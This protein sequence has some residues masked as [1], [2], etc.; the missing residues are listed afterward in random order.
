MRKLHIILGAVI[1]LIGGCVAL[2]FTLT[3]GL[4]GATNDFFTL[5]SEGETQA[6]YDSTAIE[7]QEA[8]SFTEFVDFVEYLELDDYVSSTWSHREFENNIGFVQGSVTLSDGE[9]LPLRVDLV[10]NEDWQIYGIES[11]PEE[12]DY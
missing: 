8:T 5:V 10:N 11:F 2:V 9:V 12:L 4:V 3:A 7:F 6:A 1:L